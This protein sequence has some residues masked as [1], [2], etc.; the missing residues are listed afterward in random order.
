MKDRLKFNKVKI[1]VKVKMVLW[2]GI[3]NWKESKHIGTIIAKGP[4]WYKVEYKH[5]KNGLGNTK[6]SIVFNKD[7]NSSYLMW[8]G[9]KCIGVHRG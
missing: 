8:S 3:G 5:K 4:N 9:G 2:S 1:G 7:G 6:S